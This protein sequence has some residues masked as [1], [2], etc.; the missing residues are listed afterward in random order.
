[1]YMPG[2]YVGSGT[3]TPLEAG[4]SQASATIRSKKER[5]E[6]RITKTKHPLLKSEVVRS[7][8]IRHGNEM[9]KA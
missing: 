6:T 1:M 9:N 4:A 8:D 7:R 2:L 5:L 3:G